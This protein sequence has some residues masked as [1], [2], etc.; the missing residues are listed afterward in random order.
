MI[1]LAIP[2]TMTVIAWLMQPTVPHTMI[3]VDVTTNDTL[4]PS[5]ARK[6]IASRQ[7][8]INCGELPPSKPQRSTGKE[9]SVTHNSSLDSHAN[10]MMTDPLQLRLQ[11]QLH[12]LKKLVPGKIQLHLVIHSLLLRVELP[13]FCMVV[14][15]SMESPVPSLPYH[16]LCGLVLLLCLG[17]QVPQG[18]SPMSILS[19]L[20]DHC[21]HNPL[22]QD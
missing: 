12:Q 2:V 19:H 18:W 1:A 21:M 9:L 8:G 13:S 17:H 15:Q 14:L 7:H 6:N 10:V 4:V 5:L 22:H 11:L 3:D 16:L 20:L